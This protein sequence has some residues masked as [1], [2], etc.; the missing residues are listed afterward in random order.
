M[1]SLYHLLR[2]F[3][4]RSITATNSP[5]LPYGSTMLLMIISICRLDEENNLLILIK[6]E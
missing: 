6:F 5:G 1:M 3:G 4:A 2:A